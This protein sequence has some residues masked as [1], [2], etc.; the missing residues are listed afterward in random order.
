MQGLPQEP[1]LHWDERVWPFMKIK[2]AS[3]PFQEES[4][5]KEVDGH[6]DAEHWYWCQSLWHAHP[7]E[8]VEREHLQE[9]VY[10]MTEQEA[11][12][13]LGVCLDTER[14]ARG[15]EEV[16]DEANNVAHGH[17]YARPKV[18]S[19]GWHAV[20]NKLHK[21]IIDGIL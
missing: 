7:Q 1:P 5:E 6:A 12:A 14:E 3:L 10:A 19:C 11:G 13:A 18:L 20:G 4:H 16:E 17:G 2:K 8:E 15:S 9:I 21:R